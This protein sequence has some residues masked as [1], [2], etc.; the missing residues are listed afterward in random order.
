[1]RNRQHYG[2]LTM[3]AIWLTVVAVAIT[4]WA[5]AACLI[6]HFIKG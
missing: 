5:G 3:V 2:G 6:G 4:F 1:M